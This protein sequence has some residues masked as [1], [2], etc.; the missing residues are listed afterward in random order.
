MTLDPG[1]LLAPTSFNS[2]SRERGSGAPGG[3]N[4]RV[5]DG[6]GGSSNKEGKKTQLKQCVGSAFTVGS[7]NRVL[8]DIVRLA[9]VKG[10][11]WGRVG[12]E[13]DQLQQGGPDAV[14]EEGL[15]LLGELG[16]AVKAAAVQAKSVKEVAERARDNLDAAFHEE[17][18]VSQLDRR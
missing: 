9:S 15:R 8:E 6:V 13:I 7:M 18:G 11:L 10:D 1:W 2:D 17:F 5:A 16:R 3:H 14:S 4:S 12:A